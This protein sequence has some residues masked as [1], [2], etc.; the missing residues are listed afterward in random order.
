MGGKDSKVNNHVNPLFVYSSIADDH[1][2]LPPGMDPI[3]GFQIASALV[4][5]V[6]SVAEGLTPHSSNLTAKE[7]FMRVLRFARDEFKARCSAFRK[8]HSI[9]IY[10]NC[11]D[12]VRFCYPLWT[13][14]DPSVDNIFDYYT[15]PWNP[16]RELKSFDVAQSPY[17]PLRRHRDVKSC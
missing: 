7:K 1:C 2:V 14:L 13:L 3:A 12:I 10:H 9:T 15:A 16:P 17:G 4:T 11:D 5:T 6:A 8:G